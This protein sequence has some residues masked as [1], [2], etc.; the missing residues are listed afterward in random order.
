MLFGTFFIVFDR[1]DMDWAA[2]ANP[3][4]TRAVTRAIALVKARANLRIEA[5]MKSNFKEH[6]RPIWLQAA[7]NTFPML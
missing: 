7:G 2:R 6:E 1:T 4:D 3:E 5:Y